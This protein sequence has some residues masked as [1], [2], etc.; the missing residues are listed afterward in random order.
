MGNK[1]RESGLVD[2]SRLIPCHGRVRGAFFVGLVRFLAS[3]SKPTCYKGY[4]K[5][6]IVLFGPWI[7]MFVN[8]HRTVI[9]GYNEWAGRE[10]VWISSD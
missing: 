1:I 7:E 9:E 10:Y 2:F 3:I 5:W 6:G 4:S 8:T